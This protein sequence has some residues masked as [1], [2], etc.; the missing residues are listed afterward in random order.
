MI[1]YTL[2]RTISVIFVL[3]GVLT[4]TF[5]I[6]R[7]IPADPV[8]A[9]LGPKASPESIEKLRKNWNL[10][11]PLF[12]QFALYLKNIMHG[13]FGDS[14]VTR[15]PVSK[16]IL[17][18]WPATIELATLSFLISI[19]LGVPLGIIAAV[20]QN[21]WIDH[22]SRS[23]ALL[24]TSMPAFW[25]AI[26]MLLLFYY[27][28]GWFPGAGQ[29]PLYIPRPKWITG[30]ITLDTLITGNFKLFLM[31]LRHLVLPAFCLGWLFTAT[32]T[33]ITRT[34]LLDTLSK[35]YVNTARMKGVREFWVVVKHA[36]RNAMLPTVTLLGLNYAGLLQGSVLTETVFAW[37]GLG[38]YAAR[39]FLAVDF[40]AV[41]GATILMALQYSIMNLIVDLL[42][43]YLNPEIKYD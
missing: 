17:R 27:T 42:Y 23:Y 34:S 2:R 7:I 14:I 43:A 13:D 18:F 31:S 29:L 30:M 24:G 40:P 15:E 8:A 33:R 37:P 9:A 1:N 41:I 11:R 39:S 25:L 35:E 5:F 6:T 12:T 16:A 4:I 21:S 32:T 28:L 20:K 36:F 19:I 3:I 22:L 26:M 38:R 10:D